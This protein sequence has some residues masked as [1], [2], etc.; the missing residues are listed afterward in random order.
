[1]FKHEL[2][3]DVATLAL[4]AIFTTVLGLGLAW[5][6]HRDEQGL[7]QLNRLSEVQTR[8]AR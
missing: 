3:Q 6:I 1:M 4:L 7:K 8:V 5:T 2:T